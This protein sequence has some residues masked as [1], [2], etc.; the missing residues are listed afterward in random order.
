M[1]ILQLIGN[2]EQ[3]LTLQE[4]ATQMDMARSSTSVI[5][6]TLLELNYIKTVENND[7]KFCLSVNTFFDN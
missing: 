4:I 6:P 7:K 1:A 5:V 2:N 3:G